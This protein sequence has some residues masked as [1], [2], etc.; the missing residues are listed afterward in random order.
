VELLQ[1]DTREERGW[2]VVTARGQLDVATA[3]R[4]R[5]VLVEAQYGGS[6][7]LVVDLEA[8]EFIDSFGLGV[9]VGALRRA[10]TH[11]GEVVLACS[12]ERIRTLLEVARLAEVIEVVADV[13]A[14]LDRPAGP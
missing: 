4:F 7:R 5:E 6:T 13:D 3:P 2:T 1:A 8:V 10:R 14:V 12:R 11:D 9:L